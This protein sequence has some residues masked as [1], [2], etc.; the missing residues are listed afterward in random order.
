ME[1]KDPECTDAEETRP[2]STKCTKLVI[3]FTI[4]PKV[5]FFFKTIQKL[6]VTNLGRA[7]HCL[8]VSLEAKPMGSAQEILFFTELNKVSVLCQDT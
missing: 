6:I 5:V 3:S 7:K 2:G 1:H 4:V 8:P